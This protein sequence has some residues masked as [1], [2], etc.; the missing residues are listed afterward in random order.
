MH[1]INLN[2]A[3]ME[4][5]SWSE[6]LYTRNRGVGDKTHVTQDSEHAA[7]ITM[8]WLTEW[9][10]DCL[11]DWGLQWH[12][13]QRGRRNSNWIEHCEVDS[14]RYLLAYAIYFHSLAVTV[15]SL[16]LQCDKYIL[17]RVRTMRCTVL[18]CTWQVMHSLDLTW[19]DSTS[20][21]C[22]SFVQSFDW[23]MNCEWKYNKRITS[24]YCTRWNRNLYV[25]NVSRWAVNNSRM[26]FV[27]RVLPKTT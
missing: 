10:T 1:F 7:E 22:N 6:A 21:H 11:P 15:L 26:S 5:E 8:H 19:I 14:I 4:S 9:L 2:N 24:E 17:F 20:L 13:M 27:F 16:H 18:C 12:R 3:W 25:V 23:H